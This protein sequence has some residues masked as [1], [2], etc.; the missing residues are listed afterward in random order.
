MIILVVC[1]SISAILWA[2]LS[3]IQDSRRRENT[4][5]IVVG[6][7]ATTGFLITLMAIGFLLML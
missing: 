3:L 1:V 2:L 5:Q 6:L 4:F 7:V